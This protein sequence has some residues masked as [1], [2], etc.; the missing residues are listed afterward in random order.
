MRALVEEASA[1]AQAL[2][3]QA[4]SL[5]Q[6]I[7]RYR[8]GGGSDSDAPRATERPIS[9][10]AAAQSAERRAANRP[11]ADRKKPPAAAPSAEPARKTV[12]GSDEEWKDF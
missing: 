10:R 1:A 9:A 7:A 4:S 11:W 12:A 5:T 3:E 2:T 8:V 6:L